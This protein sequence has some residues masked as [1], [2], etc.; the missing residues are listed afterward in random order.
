ME[1]VKTLDKFKSLIKG[2]PE[3]DQKRLL[4][5]FKKSLKAE[6]KQVIEGIYLPE[7]I[8]DKR[9]NAGLLHP[10]FIKGA[11]EQIHRLEII[12]TNHIAMYDPE[13]S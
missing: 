11:N 6:V 3:T 2:Y 1:C 13:A 10:D 4:R 9:V 5:F 7:I 8:T 12:K